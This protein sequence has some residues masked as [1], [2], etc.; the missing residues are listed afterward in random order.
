MTDAG[1]AVVLGGGFTVMGWEGL[2]QGGAVAE[3]WT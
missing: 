1:R 2:A 3:A